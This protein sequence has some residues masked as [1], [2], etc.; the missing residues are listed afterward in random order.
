MVELYMQNPPAS[1]RGLRLQIE[2]ALD[3][4]KTQLQVVASG[5]PLGLTRGYLY[6]GH[7]DLDQLLL[8]PR[9]S[10]QL[11]WTRAPHE[12]AAECFHSAAKRPGI[13][14]MR[15]EFF[16]RQ[17]ERDNAVIVPENA[18]LLGYPNIEFNLHRETDFS[19]SSIHELWVSEET[20]SGFQRVLAGDFASP[21]EE[22]LY[23]I[24]QGIGPRIVT[25][26]GFHHGELREVSRGTSFLFAGQLPAIDFP[27]VDV[28]TRAVWKLMLEKQSLL[29][30]PLFTSRE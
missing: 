20:A 6:H 7:E 25:L 15:T 22:T 21:Q 8:S 24:L 26:K 12:F 4:I 18:E 2:T 17:L 28:R 27:S 5:T 10:S 14:V 16:N 1:H 30:I 9:P 3:A 23:P 29:D 19:A 13:I 11:Q